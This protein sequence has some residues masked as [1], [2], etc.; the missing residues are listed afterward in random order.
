MWQDVAADESLN[1][2]FSIPFA[3][4]GAVPGDTVNVIPGFSL[5]SPAGTLVLWPDVITVTYPILAVNFDA[6]SGVASVFL[7]ASTSYTHTPV[8]IPSKAIVIVSTDSDGSGNGVTYGGVAGVL[9]DSQRSEGAIGRFIYVYGVTG[10]P[11]GAQ[12]VVANQTGAGFWSTQT[13]TFTGGD[14]TTMIRGATVKSND[15]SGTI[16]AVIASAVNDLCMLFS[17]AQT[18]D[19]A[20]TP[21]T[22]DTLR[23]S[24][25]A[26]GGVTTFALSSPGVTGNV[27]VSGTHGN[28]L[29]P[30]GIIG[31]SIKS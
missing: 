25:T 23:I 16:S 8:G 15:S 21:G 3:T 18:A 26:G 24:S 22:D 12:T 2:V 30:R 19:T 6:L 17:I 29:L 11:A 10:I 1:H 28:P 7:S 31:M 14:A 27:T 4:I 9:I 13:I 5:T 20:L